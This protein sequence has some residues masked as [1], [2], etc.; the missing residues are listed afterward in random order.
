M[1]RKTSRSL[2][3]GCLRANDDLMTLSSTT[4]YLIP[5][6][7]LLV[8]AGLFFKL[9]SEFL[10]SSEFPSSGRHQHPGSTFESGDP[11]TDSSRPSRTKSRIRDQQIRPTVEQTTSLLRDTVIPVMDL[12]EETLS[13]RVARLNRLIIG[14]GV[15]PEHLEITI[16]N[17]D[18]VLER[19]IAN[20]IYPVL[21]IRN[22]PVAVALKYT[23]DNT[24]LRYKVL[25]GRVECFSSSSIH[26]DDHQQPSNEALNANDP[27][28]EP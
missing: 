6:T 15:D 9:R 25:A 22:V 13:D 2:L 16:E 26:R 12:P 20:M 27:F 19:P 10:T 14:C 8:G 7:I 23:A 1:I 21:R 24:F 28:A 3:R 18:S 17:D 4:R 5:A 11:A